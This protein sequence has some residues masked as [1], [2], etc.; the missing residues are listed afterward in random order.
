VAHLIWI[1]LVLI[2]WISHPIGIFCWLLGLVSTCRR[3][4]CAWFICEL[5]R[6]PHTQKT[7]IGREE[8][9]ALKN[10]ESPTQPNLGDLINLIIFRGK[11]KSVY[12]RMNTPM[13][14]I[15][16]IVR[17]WNGF[18][19]DSENFWFNEMNGSLYI[20][21]NSKVHLIIHLKRCLFK[22]DLKASVAPIEILVV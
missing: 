1:E 3:I 17:N 7:T 8:S 6:T 15:Y 10:K 9:L 19:N 5:I 16:N 12:W 22:H 2:E 14:S 13:V 4:R 20:F 21:S 18:R 11:F